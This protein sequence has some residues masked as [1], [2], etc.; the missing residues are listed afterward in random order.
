MTTELGWPEIA[1]RIALTTIAGTLVGLDRGSHGRPAG[2]RTTLLV[3]LAAAV[4]MIQTNL[5]LEPAER[6][7]RLTAFLG[8]VQS[9]IIIMKIFYLLKFYDDYYSMA[10]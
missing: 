1:L 2:L 7:L 9:H 4:S 5:M 3:S 10:P 6:N 8:L